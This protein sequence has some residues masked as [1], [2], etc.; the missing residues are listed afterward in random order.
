MRFV[1]LAAILLTYVISALNG[2]PPIKFPSI[3]DDIPKDLILLDRSKHCLT[4]CED[5]KWACLMKASL[6]PKRLILE[7]IRNK[8]S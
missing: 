6:K 3:L 7:I 5:I 4:I 1:I 8:V 2:A